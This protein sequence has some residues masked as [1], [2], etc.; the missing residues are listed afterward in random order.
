MKNLKFYQTNLN[1]NGTSDILIVDSYDQVVGY[2]DEAVFD[3]LPTK[4]FGWRGDAQGNIDICFYG[5]SIGM[6]SYDDENDI[7]EDIREG[8]VSDHVVNL[9]GR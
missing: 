8:R 7:S 6:L 5:E 4:D 1:T 3:Y 9:L 2:I